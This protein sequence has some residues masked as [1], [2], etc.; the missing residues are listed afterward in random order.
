M[1]KAHRRGTE[2]TERAGREAWWRRTVRDERQA[3]RR[4][5]V[6]PAGA[7]E[8]ARRGG[9]QGVWSRDER[10]QGASGRCGST[11]AFGESMSTVTL[12]EGHEGSP[13]GAART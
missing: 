1:K 9:K 13:R 3:R 5:G 7:R 4:A 11:R 10:R 12:R 2:G 6:S 8:T